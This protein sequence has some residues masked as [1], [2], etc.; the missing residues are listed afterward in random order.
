VEALLKEGCNVSYC[1]RTVKNDDFDEFQSALD[2][3]TEQ[4]QP[5]THGTSVNVGSRDEVFKWVESAG[6]KFGRI[7]VV[8]A[9]GE[10]LFPFKA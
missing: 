6:N 3:S 5:K 4:M 8:I 7:D 9:N 1:A 10:Y 2:S